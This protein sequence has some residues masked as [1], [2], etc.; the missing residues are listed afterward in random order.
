MTGGSEGPNLERESALLQNH[1]SVIGLDEVGRG[2]VA[3]PVVVGAVLLRRNEP[4]PQGLDDSKR[5][6]ARRRESLEAPI[7]AWASH[8]ALGSASNREI[9]DV[10]IEV[11]L[12][13]AAQRALTQLPL[14]GASLLVDGP[15]SITP[16]DLCGTDGLAPMN[17]T[18]V[19][20]GDH[21]CASIAAASVLAK[22]N[23]DRTMME[24]SVH[25]DRFGWEGNK[26]YL[27]AQHTA[28]LRCHGPSKWHR[29]SWN[30]PLALP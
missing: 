24:L 22:V 30:L 26:G 14:G 7:K 12:R 3:G 21:L 19:I 15:R 2:A 23:R 8:W 20:G 18:C 17:V 9:D 28:A 11:A 10:G 16:V 4:M 27:S 1:R 6:T 25:D 29:T 13:L 5:L